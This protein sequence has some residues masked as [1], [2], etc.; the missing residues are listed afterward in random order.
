MVSLEKPS[1]FGFTVALIKSG[2][3]AT[4]PVNVVLQL[5]A[6]FRRKATSS[7]SNVVRQ[8]AVSVNVSL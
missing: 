4:F 1:L 2:A 5:L 7:V 3:V 6:T 8:L